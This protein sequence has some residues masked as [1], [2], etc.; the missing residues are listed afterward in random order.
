M[1]YRW[2][3]PV[4]QFLIYIFHMYIVTR[5]SAQPQQQRTAQ[6]TSSYP[7]LYSGIDSD[8]RHWKQNGITVDLMDK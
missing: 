5:I 6:C 1:Q 3:V 7:G 4:L 2:S 8:L